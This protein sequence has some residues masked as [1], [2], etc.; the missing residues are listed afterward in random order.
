MITLYKYNNNI[1]YNNHI[2]G[3]LSATFTNLFNIQQ[4]YNNKKHL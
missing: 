3:K 1:Y 2:I 4:Q